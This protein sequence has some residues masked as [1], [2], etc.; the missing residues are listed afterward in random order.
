MP[1]LQSL[2]ET[3]AYLW[4]RVMNWMG[5]PADLARQGFVSAHSYRLQREW[6]VMLEMLVRRI[7]YLAAP[8]VD[9]APLTPSSARAGAAR[10]VPVIPARR[11]GLRIMRTRH[12]Y[13]AP[14]FRYRRRHDDEDEHLQS[15][16]IGRLAR[17]LEE[18]RHAIRHPRPLAPTIQM[19]QPHARYKR[20]A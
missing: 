7:V 16:L 18:L 3:A 20:V 13:A 9:A 2:R 14:L 1:E 11:P 12:A 6:I 19:T 8:Q 17:K 15:M 10:S 5:N 4:W